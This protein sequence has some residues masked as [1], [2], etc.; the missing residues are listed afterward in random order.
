MCLHH[1]EEACIRKMKPPIIAY[2]ESKW[3]IMFLRTFRRRRPPTVA[4]HSINLFYCNKFRLGR[5][6]RPLAEGS[7]KHPPFA[8]IANPSDLWVPSSCRALSVYIETCVV[9]IFRAI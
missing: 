6:R 5:E 8:R 4:P 2:A 1:E 3:L 9:S 7:K